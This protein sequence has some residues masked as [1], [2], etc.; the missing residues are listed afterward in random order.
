L[1]TPITYYG[2]KQNLVK[3]ILPLIPYHKCYIEPFFGGGAL[4]FAKEPSKVEVINDINGFIINFFKV[5]KQN[6]G[7]LKKLLDITLN[8]RQQ[9]NEARVIFK[10]QENYDDVKKAW[11]FWVLT[12]ESYGR[13]FNKGW[14]FD[15]REATQ[16]KRLKNKI[17]NFTVDYSNRLKLVQ[18]ECDNALE[19]IK[20][21]DTKDSFFYCDP[22]YYN[23]DCG[24]YKGYT[25]EDYRKLLEL[26]SNI[27]G[28]FLLSSYPSDILNE[29]KIKNNWQQVIKQ[30][31]IRMSSNLQNRKYKTEL[32]VYNYESQWKF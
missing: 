23:S 27:E 1:K 14:G 15:R 10:N 30:Q 13:Q 2:G 4:F 19:V 17:D 8:S 25:I 18:I 32:L 3:D 31:Y 20:R 16:S 5:L 28:K 24:S 29:Y 26:L 12:Q 9:Y 21:F 6:Y 7:E 11:A 22:P